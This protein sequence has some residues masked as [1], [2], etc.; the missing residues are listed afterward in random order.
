MPTSPMALWSAVFLLPSCS[1]TLSS[2]KTRYEQ[3]ATLNESR[4]LNL[5][6][7]CALTRNNMK[8]RLTDTITTPK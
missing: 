5:M 7:H 3:R 6:F 2:M 8:E 1:V 4:A